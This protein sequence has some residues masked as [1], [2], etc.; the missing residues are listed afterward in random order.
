MTNFDVIVIGSGIGGLIAGGL[1]ARYGKRVLICESHAIPG[2]AAHGF[3]RQGFHF[4]TGPSF[5]CGLSDPQSLNPVRQVLQVLGETIDAIAYDPLGYYHFPEDD[6]AGHLNGGFPIYGNAQKY[7]EAVAQITPE[8]ARQLQNLEQEFLALFAPLKQIPLLTLRS[9][10]TLIPWLIRHQPQALAQLLPQLRNIQSS[11]GA[12]LNRTVSDPWVRRLFDLE[13]FLLS[14][15]TA[16]DT[17]AP[18]MAFMFGERSGS[19]IDYPVGGSPAIIQALIR[20]LKR[21]GGTLR[22]KAHVDQILVQSGKVQGIQLKNGERLTAPIVISNATVW[23][24]YHQLLK[25]EDLP[26]SYRQRALATPTVDSF[27]HLHV[28]IRAEELTDLPGHHVVIHSNQQPITHPGNICMVSIPS[29]WDSSLAP[30]GHHV[31][32]TYTLEPFTPWEQVEDYDQR[33]QERAQPLYRALETVIPDVR[34]R[35]TLELIGTPLTHRHYL[36]RYQ[37][38]YGPAIAAGKGSFPSC[39]TPISGLYRV[40]DSTMPGIGVPAVAASGI[41]CANTLVSP[42]QIQKLL[43]TIT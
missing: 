20:G 40:G 38:T 27:M 18:E 12:M 41:L 36:R 2:G 28:G 17:V 14:G 43:T 19:T 29:V 1:L 23:D 25:P 10:W 15:L 6:P 8:G 33:K 37:G 22:L 31:I 39:H 9:N 11:A 26:P 32:H 3:Q 42:K 34:S 21:W 13:C 24:T 16:Q 5:Y 4:D 35:I 7:R 30:E